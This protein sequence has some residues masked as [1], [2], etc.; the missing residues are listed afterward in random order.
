MAQAEQVARD[1]LLADIQSLGDRITIVLQRSE[2]HRRLKGK[3]RR[4][5]DHT[6]LNALPDPVKIS[7]SRLGLELFERSQS[8]HK[9]LP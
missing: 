7:F 3:Q 4:G 9:T 1:H 6:T 5:G 2:A 8:K